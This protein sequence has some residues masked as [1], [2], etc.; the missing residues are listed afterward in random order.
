MRA[1]VATAIAIAATASIAE[2][3]R[4][5]FGATEQ[6]H[7]ATGGR[8][9]VHYVT[10]TADA[11]P[12]TDA[13]GNGIPDFVEGV[14]AAGEAAV[15]AFEA[16][17]FR[18]PVSDAAIADNGG[19]GRIDIY[20]KN[21]QQADG[22]AA[23]DQCTGDICIGH[24]TTENDY[25]GFSYPSITEAI[26]T[27]V[28]HELFHL[29]QD[30]Y[31]RGQP[32]IWSEGSAVW[33][34]EHILPDNIDFDR[35]L[36]GFLLRTYRPLERGGGGFGDPYPYGAALWPYFIEQSLGAG[37]LVAIWEACEDTGDNPE[38]LDAFDAVL[39]TMSSST[40]DA[41][42]DFTRWN[43]FTDDR[44]DRG[45]YPAAAASWPSVPFEPPITAT[46]ELQIDGLSARYAELT[47]PGGPILVTAVPPPGRTIRAWLVPRTGTLADGLDFAA[48]GD[49]ISLT[50]PDSAPRE[51]YLVVTGL[52][53]QTITAA[54]PITI[55]PAPP[56]ME[57]PGGCCSA[58]ADPTTPWLLALAVIVLLGR[59]T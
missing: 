6:I 27:V 41:F 40:E 50:L 24:A 11:V 34:V 56:P 12:A 13:G 7:P 58:G 35:F 48:D 21:L 14:V 39:P 19:D 53:R 31:D 29:V 10:T 45:D 8:I 38:F 17:G 9:A 59:R 33:A 5:T 44:A 20:L 16:A 43:L 51:H 54:V 57:D 47:I 30:A 2:A 25:A 1:V 3:Q 37:A 22:N 26:E 28:S 23:V 36:P 55:E 15:A 42:T 4:P 52:T 32:T 46:A 18:A 49:V